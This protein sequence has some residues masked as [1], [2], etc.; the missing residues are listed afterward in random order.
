MTRTITREQ[1]RTLDRRAVEEFGMTGAMLMENAGRGTTDVLCSLGIEGPV[2]IVCGRGNNGGD[3][4]VIARHLDLRGH[5]VRVLVSDDPAEFQGDAALNYGVLSKCDVP[6]ERIDLAKLPEQLRGAAWMVDALLGT[7]AKG[8]PRPPYDAIIDAINDSGVPV[9]AVDVPSGLDCDT[10]EAARHT[11][12]AR[13][14]CTF[15]AAKPGHDLAAGESVRRRAS[16][17]GY[18]CAAEAG[19]ECARRIRS[20]RQGQ[21]TT[22]ALTPPGAVRIQNPSTSSGGGRVRCG[23]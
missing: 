20:A 8:E 17:R 7:G 14:T 9:L 5:A 15:V 12:R 6:I 13:H 23:G 16:G 3:G 22:A 19:A 18:W 10:G 21:A 4:Y 11:I 2:V 1:S